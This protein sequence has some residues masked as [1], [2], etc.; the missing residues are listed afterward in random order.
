MRVHLRVGGCRVGSAVV[1]SGAGA[2]VLPTRGVEETALLRD[3][4]P[5]Y[6]EY[7]ATRKRLIPFVW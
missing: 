7:A 3:L 5:A 1:C 6:A 4:G 2:V